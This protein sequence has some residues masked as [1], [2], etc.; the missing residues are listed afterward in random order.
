[1]ETPLTKSRIH[2]GFERVM[3]Q[4]RDIDIQLIQIGVDENK[5]QSLLETRRSLVIEADRYSILSQSSN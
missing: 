2:E 1:M 3:A 5:R 4:I